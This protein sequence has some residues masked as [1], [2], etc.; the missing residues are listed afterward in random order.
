LCVF[1]NFGKSLK[2]DLWLIFVVRK[3]LYLEEGLNEKE[4]FGDI[5]A[6]DHF[7]VDVG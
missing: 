7:W 6:G 1:C 5:V 3:D 4:A 2:D